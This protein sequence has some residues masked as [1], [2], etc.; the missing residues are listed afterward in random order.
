M[1]YY[2]YF[3]EVEEHFVRR[4][5][6]HMYVSPLDWSL[7]ELWRDSGVPLHVVLRG[8]DVAMDGFF[9][10]PSRREKR[11]N[12]LFYCHAS[13]M[14]EHARHLE[15][16]LGESAPADD[17]HASPEGPDKNLIFAFLDERISEI[18][19]LL[20]KQSCQPPAAS[21]VRVA[22]RLDDIRRD[23]EAN[24]QPDYESLERDLCIIDEV[25][26]NELRASLPPEQLEAW[27]KEAK[28]ELRIYRKRLPKETYSKILENFIR[29]KVHRFFNVGEFSLFHLN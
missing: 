8:I 16:H 1:N 10:R 7:I 19:S 6:K 17:A 23:I 15:T 22:T 14:E 26:V 28:E 13:V 12:T 9:S 24:K 27:Q 2:N 4:R 3:T 18:K 25:L 20:A 5:G 21:L 29:G 11:V